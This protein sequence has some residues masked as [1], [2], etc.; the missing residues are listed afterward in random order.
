MNM[1]QRPTA[2]HN[3][4]LKKTV[5]LS[6]LVTSYHFRKTWYYGIG[7]VI[8]RISVIKLNKTMTCQAMCV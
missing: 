3:R 6:S 1:V 2:I 4:L 5:S 7:Y 8:S